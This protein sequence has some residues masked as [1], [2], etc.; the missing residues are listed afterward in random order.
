MFLSLSLSLYS[1]RI[2]RIWDAKSGI[3]AHNMSAGLGRDSGHEL[4]IWSLLYLRWTQLHP[5]A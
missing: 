5:F 1:Y 2:I 3:E 4:C